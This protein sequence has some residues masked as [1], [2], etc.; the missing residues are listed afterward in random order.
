MNRTISQA[1]MSNSVISNL[2]IRPEISPC[3]M[4]FRFISAHLT[5]ESDQQPSD[6]ERSSGIDVEKPSDV[7]AGSDDENSVASSDESCSP[8]TTGE[9]KGSC[10]LVL[11]IRPFVFHHRA[12][13]IL[14]H[15]CFQML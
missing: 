11:N 2:K 5:E 1:Q 13:T 7:T 8:K 6:A 12:F 14:C 15:F 4:V 9:V 3:F 10:C